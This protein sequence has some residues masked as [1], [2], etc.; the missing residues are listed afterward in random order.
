MLISILVI[1][2]RIYLVRH[3]KTEW[4]DRGIW[5]GNVDIPLNEE[6][7]KQAEKLADRFSKV[8]VDAIYTSPL[9]RSYQTAEKIASRFFIQPMKESSLR[10]CEIS[11]WNGLTMKETLE[12]FGPFYKEWSTNPKAKIDGIESLGDVQKRLVER[13]EQIIKEP[14]ENVVVVS[15]ALAIRMVICWV[16]D[17]PIP[18]HRNFRIENASITTIEIESRPRLVCLNDTCHLEE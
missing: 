7:I 4:N 9:M 14:F 6:G 3:A 2:L 13:I 8:S 17:L 10:E 11:L 12:R 15:H 16:L 18:L 5:Q 1:I